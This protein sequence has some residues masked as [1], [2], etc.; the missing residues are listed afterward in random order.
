VVS[1]GRARLFTFERVAH[2]RS[3]IVQL[4]EE[5][6][7]IDD[8]PEPRTVV[9]ASIVAGE[10]ARRHAR[11]AVGRLILCAAPPVLTDL[12]LALYSWQLDVPEIDE[13]E[14]DFARV[15]GFAI[16]DRLFAMGLLPD[17]P[18]PAQGTSEPERTSEPE[19]QLQ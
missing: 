7:L 1:A 16:R 8:R 15:N 2:A 3:S 12:R 10:I 5:F 19:V 14:Q 9:F 13:V 18:A 17:R 11:R 4:T 6:D